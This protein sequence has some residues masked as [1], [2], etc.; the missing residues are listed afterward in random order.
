MDGTKLVALTWSD[1]VGA[2][3][4]AVRGCACAGHWAESCQHRSRGC[5]GGCAGRYRA[6]RCVIPP[7]SR[8][9]EDALCAPHSGGMPL[10]HRPGPQPL[11]E[12]YGVEE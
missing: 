12:M 2:V 5:Q 11:P 6:E 10:K 4:G 7:S 9:S 8:G 3:G 1:G